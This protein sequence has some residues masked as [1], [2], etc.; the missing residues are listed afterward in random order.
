M[1]LGLDL[2][3]FYVVAGI[4][5]IIYVYLWLHNTKMASEVTV[6]IFN[7]LVVIGK[8]LAKVITAMVNGIYA[9]IRMFTR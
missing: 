6:A 9:L 5:V 2:S 3:L 1:V 7:I 8:G 4:G